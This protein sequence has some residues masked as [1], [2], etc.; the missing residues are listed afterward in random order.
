[1]EQSKVQKILQVDSVPDKLMES[2]YVKYCPGFMVVPHRGHPNG[3]EY[4][5][6]ADGVKDKLVM[7]R[8]ELSVVKEHWPRL[9]KHLAL[10]CRRVD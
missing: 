4:H 5:S 8:V 6:N 2:W 10:Y 7:W 9:A 3:N 1:M